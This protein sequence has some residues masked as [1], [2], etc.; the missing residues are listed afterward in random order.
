MSGAVAVLIAVVSGLAGILVRNAF[1]RSND[2][3]TRQL[4]AADD[5]LAAAIP[6]LDDIDR[7]SPSILTRFEGV[8]LT[9]AGAKP[10]DVAL[11]D[12]DV[13]ARALDLLL[14]RI[15]L[16]FGSRSDPAITA[17]AMTLAVKRVTGMLHY[18]M[19][20][21]DRLVTDDFRGHL[22]SVR[23][24]VFEQQRVARSAYERFGP[25]AR[26][27]VVPAWKWWQRPALPELAEP[28]PPA[29]A[30]ESQ[31]SAPE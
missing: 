6:A 1:E 16:L 27:V 15:D 3:R 18:V 19:L 24:E 28:Q 23:T 17:R 22:E 2:L 30:D 4:Q 7:S 13:A 11:A 21:P 14:A 20:M 5:F 12:L 8:S 31:E 9:T 29:A 25:A 10:P 26:R